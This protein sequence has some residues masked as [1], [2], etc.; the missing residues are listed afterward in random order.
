MNESTESYERVE[1]ATGN[2]PRLAD[3]VARWRLWVGLLGGAIAWTIHLLVA[4][5]VAEFGCVSQTFRDVRFLGITG[6]AWLILG[7][8]AFTLVLAVVATMIARRSERVLL[9]DVRDREDEPEEFMAR[10]G[11]ITSL[12]FV[13]IIVAQTLPVLYYLTS[14]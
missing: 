4:Y 3:E 8:S 12:V 6:V 9:A 10:V 7:I 2:G 5:A 11:L 14:C 13:A 1:S